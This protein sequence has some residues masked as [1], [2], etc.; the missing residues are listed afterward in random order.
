MFDF[1]VDKLLI[2]GIVALIVIGPKDLPRVL[3]QIGQLV[4]KMRRMASEFQ[5]QFMEA[6]HEADMADVKADL[7]KL[8]QSATLDLKA[9]NPLPDL[10]DEMTA[11]IEGSPSY[12]DPR[13]RPET[14]QEGDEALA[15]SPPHEPSSKIGSSSTTLGTP[16]DLGKASAPDQV[17]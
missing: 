3:R 9:I 7:A 15:L 6:M 16:V 2:V 8:K 13:A 12:L 17:K 11:M 10:R 1:G 5:G 14:H 4:A